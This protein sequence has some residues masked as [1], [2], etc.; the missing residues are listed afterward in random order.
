M[1][2]AKRAQKEIPTGKAKLYTL[3]VYL[4]EGPMT[5]AF[6]KENKIVMRSILIRG[7]QT[8]HDLHET[9]FKAFDREEE[10]LYQFQVGGEGPMDPKARHYELREPGDEDEY[11][12]GRPPMDSQT[13]RLD[14][15]GLKV[16]RPFGYWFDFGDDWWHQINVEEISEPV[17]RTSYPKV[18]MRVGASPPQYVGW[19]EE[20]E[21]C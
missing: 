2:K 10:H 6:M 7:D 11:E 4:T 9:I 3:D 19:Q 1:I 8:L 16:G 18:V 17:P 14:E 12:D 13:A 21:P 5:E 20:D 15:L